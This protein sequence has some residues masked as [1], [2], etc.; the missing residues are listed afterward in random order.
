MKECLSC[1]ECGLEISVPEFVNDLTLE[2]AWPSYTCKNCQTN[3]YIEFYPN[4]VVLG[5]LDGV[6]APCFIAKSEVRFRDMVFSTNS[7]MIKLCI[8]G[9][10][11]IAITKPARG[12]Q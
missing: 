5:A 3:L 4:M 6:P 12:T 8:S 11:R 7:E 1:Y 10:E 2:N 9:H